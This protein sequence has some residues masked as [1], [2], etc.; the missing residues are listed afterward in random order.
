MMMM[1]I[2]MMMMTSACMVP[3]CEPVAKSN[4][5]IMSHRMPDVAA[6]RGEFDLDASSSI[7][8]RPVEMY[9][10]TMCQLQHLLHMI[11]DLMIDLPMHSSQ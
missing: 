2:M 7:L 9:S 11:I 3:S 5:F 8:T 4:N 10:G 1:M 6:R